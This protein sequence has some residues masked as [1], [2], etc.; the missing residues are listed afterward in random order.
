MIQ[1]HPHSVLVSCGVLP[2][3]QWSSTLTEGV[4]FGVLGA[5]LYQP[6]AGQKKTEKRAIFVSYQPPS[7]KCA[8]VAHVSLCRT[9]VAQLLILHFGRILCPRNPK[10]LRVVD[11]AI[12]SF[13]PN[14]FSL[15]QCAVPRIH[16]RGVSL[17]C[18]SIRYVGEFMSRKIHGATSLV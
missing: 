12:A 15:S 6:K 11:A 9:H 2:G 14:S 3:P 7:R 17:R 18:C 4:S 16:H 13:F 5:H 8:A 1:A 10:L